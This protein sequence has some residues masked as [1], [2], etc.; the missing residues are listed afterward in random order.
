MRR[1]RE[2][3]ENAKKNMRCVVTHPFQRVIILI[4]SQKEK[5]RKELEREKEEA[6]ERREELEVLCY[7]CLF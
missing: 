2:K 4:P 6:K 7:S 3:L 5:K 1:K